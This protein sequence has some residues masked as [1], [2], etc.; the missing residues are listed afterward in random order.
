[1]KATKVIPMMMRNGL[2]VGLMCLAGIAGCSQP[3]SI[4]FAPV[5]GREDLSFG[6]VKAGIS[7][8]TSDTITFEVPEGTA[9][10]LIE[11]KGDD[12][13][14]FLKKL[15]DSNGSNHPEDG[16]VTRSAREVPG[17]SAMTP[18]RASARR[19]SSAAFADL[20]PSSRAISARVG[21]MP[22]SAMMLWMRRRI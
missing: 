8:G 20:K 19:C 7:G 11:V 13:M 18:L 16:Y 21:G 2:C 9:S 14:Y 17:M 15:A 5:E 6:S 3:T 12:G 4:T 22:V 10:L 1:M